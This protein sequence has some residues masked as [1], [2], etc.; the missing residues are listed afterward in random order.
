MY[1]CVN[2]RQFRQF[3]REVAEDRCFG[4]ESVRGL[5]GYLTEIDAQ[6][7]WH[8]HTG[9]NF[10]TLQFKRAAAE[11]DGFVHWYGYCYI[12]IYIYIC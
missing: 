11:I 3:Q 12:Y 8:G 9:L 1:A 7:G 6:A 10:E 2:Q 4:E 5:V